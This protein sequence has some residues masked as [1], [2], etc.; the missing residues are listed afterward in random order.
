M[1]EPMTKQRL[2]Q[3]YEYPELAIENLKAN[4]REKA[5]NNSTPKK[6]SILMFEAYEVIVQ[7]HKALKEKD[8]TNNAEN[9]RNTK[10]RGT[11]HDQGTPEG[12]PDPAAREKDPGAAD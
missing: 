5:F 4:L 1:G 2:S 11:Q 10:K 7:L 12:I 9:L 6:Y 8:G 3:L